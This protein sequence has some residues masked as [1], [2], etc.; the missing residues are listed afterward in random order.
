MISTMNSTENSTK[1]GP[2]S[3]LAEGT[4]VSL[5]HS[6]FYN[7]KIN[8]TFDL[9]SC[10]TENLTTKKTKVEEP[11]HPSWKDG[12]KDE[13]N[14]SDEESEQVTF[15]QRLYEI[16]EEGAQKDAMWWFDDGNGFC[17]DPKLFPASVLADFFQVT[18]FES[19][20]RK[21][22]RWGFK[23][24]AGQHI[25]PGIIA[26]YHQN[27][28][29]DE[30]KLLN[31]M[32]GVKTRRNREKSKERRE[33]SRKE[34]AQ[35]R[36]QRTV[37]AQAQMAM[38]VP[39]LSALSGFGLSANNRVATAP[40]SNVFLPASFLAPQ[41]A[42]VG[43]SLLAQQPGAS[44]LAQKPGASLLAQQQLA[45]APTS[46]QDMLLQQLLLENQ[47]KN[48]LILQQQ[49]QLYAAGLCNDPPPMSPELRQRLLGIQ[50]LR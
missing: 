1:R 23:R 3:D 8:L 35:L 2:T 18:K 26:F 4:S 29:R 39:L 50:G 19:F 36:A 38:N 37:Q 41:H 10:F 21:L 6:R 22:N 13:A 9:V 25:P 43:S 40:G 14:K 16:L 17:V 27:F 12:T 30:P 28:K 5:Y 44:F 33:K 34:L 31:K 49:A 47:K 7:G 46:D 20:T 15:P 42:P 24:A 32:S 11:Q 45:A 48:Q